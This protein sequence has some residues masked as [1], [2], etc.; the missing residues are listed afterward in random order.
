MLSTHPDLEAR[1]S[2]PPGP[3]GRCHQ[4]GHRPLVQV[5]EWVGVQYASL[6]VSAHQFPFGVV[7]T[8]PE[9]HLGEVVGPE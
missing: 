9:H 3:D 5:F 6:P 8:Q 4:G 1:S 7:P 2:L